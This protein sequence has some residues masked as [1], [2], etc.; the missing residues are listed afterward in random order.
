MQLTITGIIAGQFA[1]NVLHFFVSTSTDINAYAL[2]SGLAVAFHTDHWDFYKDCLPSDYIASSIR[3]KK[4]ATADVPGGGPTYTKTVDVAG[5]TGTRVGTVG[6]SS[7][8]PILIAPFSN[9]IKNVTGKIYLPGLAEADVAENHLSDSLIGAVVSLADHLIEHCDAAVWGGSYAWRLLS[10][11]Q[12][13]L[14][15]PMAGGVS[16]T[17][18]NLRRRNV[19]H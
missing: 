5:D 3:V 9:G 11:S 16:A 14:F 17:I 7:A 10:P 4:I 8:C 13:N 6:V 18:G 2:A 19:P 15:P 12:N 1:Q